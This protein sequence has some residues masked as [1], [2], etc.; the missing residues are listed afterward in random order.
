MFGRNLFIVLHYY[1]ST[2]PLCNVVKLEC[3]LV[4]PA[5]FALF[6]PSF[7]DPHGC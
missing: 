1:A 7:L 4:H 2:S 3:T 5:V 6:Y